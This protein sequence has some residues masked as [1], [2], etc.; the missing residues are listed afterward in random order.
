MPNAVDDGAPRERVVRIGDPLGERGAAGSFVGGSR[1]GKARLEGA[2]GG[3][4][5]GRSFIAGL[6]DVAAFED[7]NGPGR[8]GGD[9]SAIRREVARARVNEPGLWQ[10]CELGFD[11]IAEIKG[12]EFLTLFGGA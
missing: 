2:D 10:R 3:E 5:T 4:G 8:L 11:L 9:K 1:E 6:V 12:S 7:M